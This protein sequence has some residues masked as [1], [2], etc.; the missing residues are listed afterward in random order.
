MAS[1]GTTP[2]SASGM[3]HV[4]DPCVLRAAAAEAADAH[5]HHAVFPTAA[6]GDVA[7]SEWQTTLATISKAVVVLKARAVA[8]QRCC[9]AA[10]AR[11]RAAHA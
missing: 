5:T 6:D 7:S 1:P 2:P 11:W 9:S 3:E 8:A 4:R 10:C